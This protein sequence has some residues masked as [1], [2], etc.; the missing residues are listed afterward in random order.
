M[1][2][3]ELTLQRQTDSGYPVIASFTRLGKLEM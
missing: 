1:S 3:F 2:T